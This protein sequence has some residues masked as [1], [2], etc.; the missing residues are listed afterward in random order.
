MAD[1][2]DD[3]P[4]RR[5]VIAA[6][7]GIAALLVVTLL[8]RPFIFSLAGPRDDRNYPVISASDAD[9]G[10]R[11]IE[12][13]LNDPHDLPGEVVRDAR[14]G[15][16]VV[17]APLPGRD[18]YS[19]V[20]AWSPANGCALEIVKDRLRDCEGTAW[21]YEGF[22]IDSADPPLTAFPVTVRNG[23]VIVDFTAA[24]EPTAS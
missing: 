6:A 5:Y 3:V 24:R 10:P 22:P 17:V 15:Y 1:A 4:V 23:A 20:G 9:L 16:T 13:V 18:G 19:V 11:R 12:I 21:T 14:V 7:L 2:R 8:V